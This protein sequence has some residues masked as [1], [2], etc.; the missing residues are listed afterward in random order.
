MI[1]QPSFRLEI[2]ILFS[3]PHHYDRFHGVRAFTVY[4]R[5]NMSCVVSAGKPRGLLGNA[6]G[7]IKDDLQTPNNVVIPTNATLRQLYEEFG[8]KCKSIS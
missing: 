7:D 4:V 3:C 8:M 2:A 6:N 1:N 5:L